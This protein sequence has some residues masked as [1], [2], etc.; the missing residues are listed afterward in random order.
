[1]SPTILIT[2]DD[3]ISSVG[4]QALARVMSRLGTVWVVAPDRERTAVGHALTLHKPLRVT[5]VRARWY[6]V[7]GTPTDCVNLAVQQVLP[8]RPALLVSGINRGVNLG[9]DVTYSGTVSA[10]LEGTIMGIPSL[11]VSQEGR[12]RF[13]FP[14]GAA[15]ALV[16]ARMMLY[17][18]LPPETLL[19]MNVPDQPRAAIRGLRVTRLSRRRFD[20][21]IIEKLDPHGRHYYWIA[22][23]RIT[24]KRQADSDHTALRER[25]VSVTP[26]HLDMTHVDV[27]E[28][29]RRWPPFVETSTST[30]RRSV[31]QG[32]GA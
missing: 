32:A 25:Y 1:M 13:R 2:N 11:A 7:N 20:N 12:E 23:T 8:K 5:R 9:D 14:V 6:S 15:Y 17:Q 22:G 19:N 26:L 27:L 18:A 24:W 28:E 3:G 29:I 10:A 30:R 31:S 4:L 21:P 16:V